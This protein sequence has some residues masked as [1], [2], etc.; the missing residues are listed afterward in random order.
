[1]S[2]LRRKEVVPITE[3]GL[4]KMLEDHN[5]EKESSSELSDEN[6]NDNYLSEDEVTEKPKKKTSHSDKKGNQRKS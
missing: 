4:K 6:D 1:M 3:L 5:E 2:N